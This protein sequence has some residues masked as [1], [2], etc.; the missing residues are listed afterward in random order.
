[1]RN[2]ILYEDFNNLEEFTST[3]PDIFIE[4]GKVHWT[5]HRDG[6]IQYI[7]REIQ[8]FNGDFTLTVIGQINSASNNCHVEVGVGDEPGNGVEILF[9]W[10]GGGCPIQGYNIRTGGILLD[11]PAHECTTS[12]EK[13][14]WPWIAGGTEYIAS[15]T[16]TGNDGNL[17]IE[18]VGE[19]QG[20]LTYQGSFDTLYVGLTGGGDWPSCSGE[21]QSI[22]ISQ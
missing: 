21:I 11:I 3:D 5:V 12:W 20:Y 4:D 19:Y 22:E 10:F 17:F 13:E 1:M 16:V 6:G 8:S 14:K 15:V 9:S 2:T 18:G 7:Y